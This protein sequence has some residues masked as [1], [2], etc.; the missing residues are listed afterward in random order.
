MKNKP[1]VGVKK[2]IRANALFSPGQLRQW[3]RKITLRGILSVLVVATLVRHVFEGNYES[4]F[5]CVLTLILFAIPLIIDRWL[6]VD[7]PVGLESVI[8]CF[9]FAAEILGEIDS[10]YT[11][12][13]HWDTML[14]TINGF[15]MAAIGFALVDIFNRTERFLFKLSPLFLAVVA[16]CFSMT[17]GVL[18]EFF[19]FFMDSVFSMDMQKDYIVRKIN[20]VTFNPDGLNIV[21]HVTIESLVVNGEDWMARYGGYID[22]GLIDT[23]KDLIVNFVGAVV[24]SIIGF[25]YVKTRGQG[26]FARQFIPT[27]RKPA[28]SQEP[29]KIEGKS[30]TEGKKS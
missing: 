13:K 9:I 25:F 17:V 2:G 20:S 16:F 14:H 19:E 28:L 24:F 3:R 23:M 5:M 27:V 26:K 4:V 29:K 18:W 7:I 8:L 22:I 10:F 21:G 1:I 15:L 12:F 6:S 30:E 11:R